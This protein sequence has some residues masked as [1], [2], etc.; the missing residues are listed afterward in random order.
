MSILGEYESIRKRIG[1]KEFKKIG[2]YLEQNKDLY[3]SDIY[4]RQS[5]YDKFEK[6]KK[7]KESGNVNS[8]IKKVKR[9]TA[10]K[11]KQTRDEFSRAQNIRVSRGGKICLERFEKKRKADGSLQTITRRIYK[12]PTKSNIKRVEENGYVLEVKK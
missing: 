12:K 8:K 2:E 1:E 6:W 3:L 9:A 7:K 11:P 4:Y 5:E 10:K